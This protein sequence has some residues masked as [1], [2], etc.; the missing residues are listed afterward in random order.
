MDILKH[1]DKFYI[2]LLAPLY[3]VGI[4][5]VIVLGVALFSISREL[6][7]TP[8]TQDGFPNIE[9]LHTAR[10]YEDGSWTAEYQ[11]GETVSGCKTNGLCQ[12]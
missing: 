3:L 9:D 4:M 5:F 10:L 7:T 1:Q 2:A 12:D 6:L 11:S 8:H